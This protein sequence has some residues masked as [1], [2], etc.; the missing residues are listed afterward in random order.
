MF[1][2]AMIASTKD[3]LLL[4]REGEDPAFYIPLRDIYFEFLTETG[5]ERD[6]PG[7]GRTRYW[8]VQAVGESAQDVMWAHDEPPPELAPIRQH[9]AFDPSRMRI[10]AVPQEDVVHVPHAP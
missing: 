4:H 10:E 8:N 9:A 3:A 7:R 2:D 6:V 1:S 5:T